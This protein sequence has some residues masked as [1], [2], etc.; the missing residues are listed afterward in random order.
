MHRFLIA[1]SFFCF[2]IP[3]PA[4][5]QTAFPAISPWTDDED[6]DFETPEKKK[7][8]K[9]ERKQEQEEPED[10]ISSRDTEPAP[11]KPSVAAAL[12]EEPSALETMYSDRI[13]DELSQFGYDLFGVPSEEIQR[14]LDS[15]ASMPSGAVQDDFILNIGD[16]VEVVFSG[17]RTDRETYK[18]NDQGLLLINDFPPIPAAGREIGQVRISIETAAENLHNTHAYVSLS[19][20][21]QIGVLVVGHVKKP[22]RQTLTVFHTVLDALMESGGIARTGSLRQIKLVRDGRGTIIDLYGLLMHGSTNMDLRL[23]DGDRLIVPP[24][25]PTVAIAGEVKRPGIYEILPVMKGMRHLPDQASERLSLN[26]MLDLGG[27]VLAP[28]QNRFLRMDVTPQ[29]RE[30]VTEVHEAFESQFGDGSVLIVAKGQEKRAQTVELVGHTRRPGIHALQEVPTLSALLDDPQ[31][32]GPKAYP[33]IGVIE[34]WDDKQMT[35]K[36]MDFPLLLVLKGDYDRKLEDGDVVHLFSR[37]QIAALQDDGP[38]LRDVS[39]GS[40]EETDESA[41]DDPVMASFLR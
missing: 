36:L 28:G 26:E 41:I 2:L 24:V 8:A 17:Q 33:L 37:Q 21:R 38:K 7:P 22:G 27:G 13:V 3:A 29:G 19:S 32:L 14:N 5:A 1:L 15:A 16:E 6:F 10:L 35:T 40:G 4:F 18:V 9:S 20:V 25:G 31:V 34:R 12:K 39:L 30:V 23:R 11:R